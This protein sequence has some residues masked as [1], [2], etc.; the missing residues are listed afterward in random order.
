MK[1]LFVILVLLMLT[2]CAAKADAELYNLQSEMNNMSRYLGNENSVVD[3]DISTLNEFFGDVDT[4]AYRLRGM[5]TDFREETIDGILD[6]YSM[7]ACDL[8]CVDLPVSVYF[9]DGESATN[10]E[11]IEI[12]GE[13]F[14]LDGDNLLDNASFSIREAHIVERGASVR[15]QIEDSQND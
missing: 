12:V 6:D 7:N 13:L 15:E 8:V 2:G 3:V 10:G 4:A 5:V 9:A 1:R 14:T 11:Y